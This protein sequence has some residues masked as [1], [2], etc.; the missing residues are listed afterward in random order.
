[1][2]M[3]LLMLVLIFVP[4]LVLIHAH[5]YAHVIAIDAHAFAH[6]AGREP[7]CSYSW[8]VH[9]PHP[10]L[11]APP[12]GMCLCHFQNARWVKLGGEVQGKLA[13]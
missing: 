2:L 4:V 9:T 7:Q 3:L 13:G 6:T 5:N 12:H 10:G 1:M 11:H 8:G